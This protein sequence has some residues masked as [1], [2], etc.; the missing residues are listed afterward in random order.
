MRV[1]RGKQSIVGV[2]QSRKPMEHEVEQAA[3][4]CYIHRPK[5]LI[6]CV[7]YVL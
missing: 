2:V 5:H 7:V 4:T 3:D 1:R 6:C